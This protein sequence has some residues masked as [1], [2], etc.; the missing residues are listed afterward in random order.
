M[1]TAF[2]CC[3]IM[4]SLYHDI[5]TSMVRPSQSDGRTESSSLPP[6]KDIRLG[7][8]QQPMRI[9]RTHIKTSSLTTLSKCRRI[10]SAALLRVWMKTAAEVWSRHVK[11]EPCPYTH[12]LHQIAKRLHIVAIATLWSLITQGLGPSFTGQGEEHMHA[13]LR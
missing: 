7:M 8:R 2:F 5:K 1:T 11:D 12:T 10:P 9:V 3:F 6:N 4:T 13:A